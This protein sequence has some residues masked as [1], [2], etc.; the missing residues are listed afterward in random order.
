MYPSVGGLSKELDVL[1][2]EHG[3]DAKIINEKLQDAGSFLHFGRI[4]SASVEH[5]PGDRAGQGL[6]GHE[7]DLRVGHDAEPSTKQQG[8]KLLVG[9]S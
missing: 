5:G 3:R 6:D 4:F 2:P 1:T 8:Q 9:N 7:V